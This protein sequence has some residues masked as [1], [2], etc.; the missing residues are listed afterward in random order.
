[1]SIALLLVA[2]TTAQPTRTLQL[3]PDQAPLAVGTS[4]ADKP[5]LRVFPSTKANGT[6]VVICP[7]GGYGFLADDHEGKQVAEFFNGLLGGDFA[8][9]EGSLCSVP[10]RSFAQPM[11][12]T[13]T[14]ERAAKSSS[15]P[16]PPGGEGGPELCIAH[17]DAERGFGG[18]EVQVFLLMEG[19]SARGHRNVLFCPPGSA[20]EG[21]AR[22]RGFEVRAVPMRNY[23]D[24][25]A[26]RG[27][28]IALARQQ[29]HLALQLP[30]ASQ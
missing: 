6:A 26:V 21:E 1:M 20:G 23:L 10:A 11:A 19:L 17:V 22:R 4:E 5:S 8:G 28:A 30:L 7:G 16:P 29:R 25:P 24:L 3:W 12:E 15:L 2:L 27:L 18:G 13:S 9:P 14:S